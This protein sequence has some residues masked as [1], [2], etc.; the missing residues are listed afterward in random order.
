MKPFLKKLAKGA[1]V[2]GSVVGAVALVTY[3]E[4]DD[5]A[6][7]EDPSGAKT[8]KLLTQIH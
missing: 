2:A 7:Q 6:P 8:L 5:E 1:L 4:R 3:M